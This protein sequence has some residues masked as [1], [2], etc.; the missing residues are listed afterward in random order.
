M[1][2]AR[3]PSSEQSKPIIN[4]WACSAEKLVMGLL[5]RVGSIRR[6]CFLGLGN[7]ART[8]E[9]T[10][11]LDSLKSCITTLVELRNAYNGQLDTSAVER[12]DEVIIEL[13]SLIESNADV[14]A[15]NVGTKALRII[16]DILAVVT[17]LTDLM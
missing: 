8:G 12:L 11:K 5:C 16:A 15:F 17:N 2:V 13:Q 14:D 9:L 6:Y 3:H 1:F 4:K 7:F 10:M